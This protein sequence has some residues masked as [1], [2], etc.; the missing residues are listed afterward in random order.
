MVAG[1]LEPGQYDLATHEVVI[2][3]RIDP[4][5]AEG[6]RLCERRLMQGVEQARWLESAV[7]GKHL[8]LRHEGFTRKG[9]VLELRAKLSEEGPRVVFVQEDDGTRGTR[10]VP[11][12]GTLT[13]K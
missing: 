5:D 12:P 8:F 6:V 7:R 9:D 11:Q 2:A 10:A 1:Q 3:E 4:A 13:Q